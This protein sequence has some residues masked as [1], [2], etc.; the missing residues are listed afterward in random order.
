MLQPK[1]TKHRKFQKGSIGG[2]VSNTLSLSF[3]KFGM[4][5]LVAGRLSSQMIEAARRSMTRKFKRNGQIWIRV[6][7][8]IGVSEKPAEVRMGKG[9][10][11]PSFWVCRVKIGQILFEFEGISLELAKQAAFLAA[12]K[13]PL[14][15]Q[16]VLID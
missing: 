8:D 12:Q 9:K 7:P 2:K 10:G 5:S 4:K 6:F 16:F 14:R 1:R 3:G 15:T 11:N 13:I